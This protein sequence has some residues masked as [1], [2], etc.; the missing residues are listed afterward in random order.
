VTMRNFAIAAAVAVGAV[1]VYLTATPRGSQPPAPAGAA[2]QFE[3]APPL[4]APA[5]DGKIVSLSDFKGKVVLVD[6]WATWCDPCKEELPVLVKMYDRLKARGFVVLGV[7]MDE[8][9]AVAVKK[10]AAK[11]PISYPVVLNNGERAPKGW[12]APGLPTAYL[13]GRDGTVRERWF[14]EKDPADLEKA[15]NAALAK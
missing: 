1:V 9:G 14:G 10:F 15:V 11:H 12:T 4:S 5:L 8:E 2:G 13:I 3:A 7:S 6:F